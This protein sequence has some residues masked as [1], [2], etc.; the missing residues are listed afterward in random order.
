MFIT[1]FL[2]KTVNI[3]W[4]SKYSYD[5]ADSIC[6]W[7]SRI[8]LGITR[9][10]TLSFVPYSKER[11]ISKTGSVFFLSRGGWRHLLYWIYYKELNSSIIDRLSSDLRTQKSRCLQ[12]NRSSF[13]T[14][15]NTGPRTKSENL[16]MSTTSLCS[17]ESATGFCPQPD[18][19]S[20]HS[21]HW[22]MYDVHYDIILESM[23]RIFK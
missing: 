3:L 17:Q 19:T 10:L 22:L 23:P 1:R 11:N 2:K 5:S 6:F 14:A 20:L 12:P 16:V 8:T 4:N 13:W 21:S 7:W 9:Y 15:L 18:K